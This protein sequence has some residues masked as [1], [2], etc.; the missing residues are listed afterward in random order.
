MSYLQFKSCSRP[1]D[2][3]TLNSYIYACID[4][5]LSYSQILNYMDSF[6]LRVPNFHDHETGTATALFG[7]NVRQ[8]SII[9]SL[10]TIIEWFVLVNI[11]LT[12]LSF[13]GAKVQN[14][15]LC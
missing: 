10:Y 5:F 11:Q 15:G 2:L 12:N 8:L 1:N 9:I 6:S 14:L 3:E 4:F 7:L 13:T